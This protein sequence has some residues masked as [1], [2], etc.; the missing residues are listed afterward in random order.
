LG[1]VIT[2][3]GP[4]GTGKST[5]GKMIADEFNLRHISI[6]KIFREMAKQKNLSLEEFSLY[7]EKHPEIDN[8]LD[9]KI[10]EEAKKGENVIID[11][12]LSAWMTKD[13]SDI[14]IYFT[15]PDSVRIQRIAERDNISFEEAKKETIARE[16]S[17]KKRYKEIYNID[18]TDL[19]IYDLILNTAIWPIES[20]FQ[21]IKKAINE[22]QKNM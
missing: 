21:I 5:Y 15:A 19:S 4:H 1:L 20:I 22:Y 13:L 14:K 2:V 6:G 7:V 3:A 10:V 8:E 11:S 16:N 17:E 12:Q 18:I 9:D